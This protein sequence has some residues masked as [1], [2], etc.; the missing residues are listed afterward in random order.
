MAS[1]RTV[2]RKDASRTFV[3]RSRLDAPAARVFRWHARPGAFER[4]TPP[5]ERV[6]VVARQGGIEDGGRLEMRMGNPPLRIRWV[7]EHEGYERDRQFRDVQVQG[8]FA[9]WEHTHRMQPDGDEACYLEDRIDY[10]LPLGRLG[11]LVAGA[12][13]RQRLQRMFD[14]RHAVTA[15]DIA[16]HRA[17]EGERPMRVLVSGASGLIGSALVPFLTTGG[18]PVRRLVRRAAGGNDDTA[19]WDPTAGRIDEGALDGIDAV[20]HLAGENISAGRWTAER[21]RRILDSRVRSTQLLAQ[22]LAAAPQRPRAFVCASAIGFYGDRGDDLV[23][24][25]AVA[26]SGFL[27]DVCKAWEEAAE[28]ARRAGIRV[29]HLRFGVVLS[30]QG[31]ALAKMLTP[32][33]L[34]VGGIVG[35]GRQHMSWIAH[36]DAVGAVHHALTT[37]TLNGAVNVVAPGV[38]TNHEYTKTLGRVLSRPTVFPVPAFAARLAFGEMADELLLASTRVQPLK[39]EQSGYVFRFAQL[40]PALRH[41]LGK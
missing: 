24:D 36:D 28:P 22:S 31:G 6:E 40:E 14:Y 7:A 18:H 10:Q 3:H 23:D 35:D 26:G 29:V 11:A 2:L 34:G 1:A 19:S 12:M 25:N 37:D 4:L 5:W 9:R 38:V 39:L 20:V 32:F 13:V 27:A 8:P 15:A 17:C 41:M 33:R 16:A 21:K 30:P